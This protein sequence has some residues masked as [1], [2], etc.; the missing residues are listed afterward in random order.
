MAAYE[1]LTYQIDDR[2]AR[3]TFNRP[4]RMN[5]FNLKLCSEIM[6]AI[7]EADADPEVR[8]LLLTGAGGKAFSAGYDIKETA[9]GGPKRGEPGWR[10]RLAKDLR[11]CYS[12]WECSKPVIAVIDGFCLAGALEFAQMCD[13]RYCSEDSKFGVLETRFAAG[14]VT[15]IMPWI[16][17]PASRE[18]VFTGDTIGAAEAERVGLVTR[19]Y[20]K[21]TLHAETLKIAKRMSRVAI[22]CLTW[23]KRAMNKTSEIMGLRSALDF[24]FESCVQLDNSVA[25][26]YRKFDALRREKGLGEAIKWRDGQFAPYE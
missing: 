21:A 5:A 19:V 7:A 23:N 2:V 15:M 10:D 24:G 4:E 8:V 26:E 16:L 1:T 9:S 22:E 6:G 25:P 14:I 12:P 3:I 18:L 13:I 17:G 20:P 11:F